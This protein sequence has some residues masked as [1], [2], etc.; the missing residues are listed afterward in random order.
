MNRGPGFYRTKANKTRPEFA[1]E[2][3]GVGIG[4]GRLVP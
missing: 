1:I 2:N 4:L 3:S